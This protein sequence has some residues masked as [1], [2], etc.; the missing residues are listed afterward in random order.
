MQEA[1]VDG[2]DDR[3]PSDNEEAGLHGWGAGQWAGL[4]VERVGLLVDR[5]GLLI[6]RAG[7]EVQIVGAEVVEGVASTAAGTVGSP[8]V[9]QTA[10]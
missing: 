8:E 6:E 5:A 10:G 2:R 1:S 4:L 7:D 3:L 9:L